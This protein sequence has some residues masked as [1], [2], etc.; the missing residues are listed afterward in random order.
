MSSGKLSPMQMES[1]ETTPLN[2]GFFVKKK[3]AIIC[4]VLATTIFV[5]SILITYFAKSC[6]K[7]VPCT[8]ENIQIENLVLK[9]KTLACQYQEI[10]QCKLIEY[11]FFLTSI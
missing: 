3:I 4:S 8:V 10:I 2:T 5:G 6:E 1:P 9:C 7:S 11:K